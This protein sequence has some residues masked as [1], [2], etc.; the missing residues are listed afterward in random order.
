MASLLLLLLLFVLPGILTWGLVRLLVVYGHGSSRRRVLRIAVPL[1][2]TLPLLPGTVWVAMTNLIN[3][4]LPIAIAGTLM[5]A[6]VV[7]LVVC[8][9]VGLAATRNL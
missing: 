1:G 4:P 8:L 5:I 7:A 3:N 9:P 6:A 2:A